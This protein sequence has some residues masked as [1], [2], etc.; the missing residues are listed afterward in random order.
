MHICSFIASS[1]TNML[2]KGNSSAIHQT[3]HRCQNRIVQTSFVIQR[4][5][6]NMSRPMQMPKIPRAGTKRME[7]CGRP[8]L[9]HVGFQHARPSTPPRAL[10]PFR[11]CSLCSVSAM[12]VT[13]A[14]MY[15]PSRR[16]GCRTSIFPPK[17]LPAFD[18][19]AIALRIW[20]LPRYPPL[21]VDALHGV[22]H[23]RQVFSQMPLPKK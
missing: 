16:P 4:R 13:T 20:R 17:R 5:S 18:Y 3:A 1:S 10:S 11:P 7:G 19:I 6:P 2:S 21:S 8:D 9:H 14:P 23:A 15:H 22:H 12:S